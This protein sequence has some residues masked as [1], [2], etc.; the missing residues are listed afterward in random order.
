MIV[1]LGRRVS[2]LL[3]GQ[4]S[5]S[6]TERAWQHVHLCHPC[7]DLVEREGRVK[8][9]LAGLAS[10]RDAAAPSYLKGSLLGEIAAMAPAYPDVTPAS[11]GRS[12]QRLTLTLIGVSALGLAMTG[13]FALTVP[14]GSSS[15]GD[16]RLPISDLSV[17]ERSVG[18]LSA[19]SAALPAPTAITPVVRRTGPSI[20]QTQTQTRPSPETTTVPSV[21]SV[22]RGHHFVHLSAHRVK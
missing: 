2:A 22:R 14:L 21:Q 19:T 20:S 8:T 5:P 17:S 7:R 3:D 16:R 10:V 11:A 13:A 6:E 15:N 12:Q 1:H 4:L 18:E 9:Q